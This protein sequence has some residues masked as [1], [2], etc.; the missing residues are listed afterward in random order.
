MGEARIGRENE[1]KRVAAELERFW[2]CECP[3]CGDRYILP[4][5][6]DRVVCPC[7]AVAVM[8]C[9]GEIS[10]MEGRNGKA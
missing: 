5:L 4:P 9:S 2:N 8:E 6:G 10:W 1:R 3:I 7:G